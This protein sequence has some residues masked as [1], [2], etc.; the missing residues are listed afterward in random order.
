MMKH[1]WYAI[2][3]LLMLSILAG[4][5]SMTPTGAFA[6]NMAPTWDAPTTHYTTESGIL[7]IDLSHAFFDP[8]GDPLQYTVSVAEPLSASINEH[9]LVIVA[10]SSGEAML[11]ASDGKTITLQKITIG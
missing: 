8:D 3:L 7:E 5:S 4:F 11:S 2:V 9:Q 6:A 1:L 10:P